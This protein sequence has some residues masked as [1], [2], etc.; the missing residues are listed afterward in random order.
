MVNVN[1]ETLSIEEL[2]EIEKKLVLEYYSYIDEKMRKFFPPY[3]LEATLEKI[4]EVLKRKKK[5]N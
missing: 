2:E 5:E 4:Q 3:S 1:F